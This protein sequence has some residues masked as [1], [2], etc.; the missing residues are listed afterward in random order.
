MSKLQ[1][2]LLHGKFVDVV[3]GNVNREIRAIGIFSGLIKLGLGWK[4]VSCEI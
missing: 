1:V 2:P 4:I 3:T